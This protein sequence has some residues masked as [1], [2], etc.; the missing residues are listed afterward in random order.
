MF[1]KVNKFLC[2]WRLHALSIFIVIVIGGVGIF[3][4]ADD[5][6]KGISWGFYTWTCD[7]FSLQC[8]EVVKPQ[9]VNFGVYDFNNTFEKTPMAIEHE[10]VSWNTYASGTIETT[11]EKIASRNRWP[12]IT[13]EPWVN[14]TITSSEAELL[15]DVI[16]GKYDQTITN[17]CRELATFD[18]PL[19]LRWG[20]EMEQGI[21]RYPWATQNTQEY[22]DAYRHFVTTCKSVAQNVYYVWSPAGNN[23]ADTYWPGG[24]YV[25][26][27][28]LSLYELS[29][30][31]NDIYGK[32]QSF[33][34]LLIEKYDRVKKF[35]KP[36]MIAEFGVFGSSEFQKK[37]MSAAFA[38]MDSF[39]LLKSVV[40]FNAPDSFGAWP[41]KYG[42]PDWTIEP[43]IF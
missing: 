5:A 36:I 30:F 11:L 7:T 39:E 34:E 18:K 40:Y 10:Y 20:H 33:K 38:D 42:I 31:D 4:H 8:T 16:S 12:L 25:D 35:N 1:K 29:A 2:M 21:G 37:W 32:Q 26:Y 9:R 23:G 19:F 41:E 6:W 13:V 14:E 22:T 17:I 15:V 27:V 24:E 43:S 3:L 28:G